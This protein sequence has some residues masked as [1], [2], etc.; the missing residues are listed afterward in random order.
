[1]YLESLSLFA[2]RNLEPCTL[3]FSPGVNAFF[4]ENGAGKTNLLEAIH[5]L[6]TTRG[7]Y[8]PRDQE[9]LQFGE[10]GFTV[11]GKF[12]EGPEKKQ[13][14][15]KCSYAT[16][17]GKR[18]IVDEVPL[19]RLSEHIGRFPVV[20]FLPD[21]IALIREGNSGFRKWL[22]LLLCQLHESYLKTLIQ[23]ENALEKRNRL[24]KI[25]NEG[26]KVESA[27]FEPY[28]WILAKEGIKIQKTRLDFLSA[29]QNDFREGYRQVSNNAEQPEIEY[30]P[31]LAIENEG[32]RFRSITSLLPRELAAGRSLSGEHRDEFN[33]ILA[34]KEVKKFASQGQEKTYVLALK[35]ATVDYFKNKNGTYPLFLLDDLFDRLDPNRS[36]ALADWI[37][38]RIELQAFLTHTES[39]MLNQVFFD[40]KIKKEVKYF[41]VLRGNIADSGYIEK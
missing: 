39:T 7:F 23:Y 36:K 10:Y 37:S 19:N 5:Y 33:F 21:D 16:G 11:T 4:G 1:L 27:E 40:T 8:G 25:A 2:F 30:F 26:K 3:A 35:L 20:T 32:D 24:L 15:I 28:S 31:N 6:S 22:D 14:L 12:I 38:D 13:V 29:F 17:K 34:G 9:S 41:H 18:L